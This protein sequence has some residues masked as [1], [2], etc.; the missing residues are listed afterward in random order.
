MDSTQIFVASGI[1]TIARA[2]WAYFVHSF[3]Q[4]ITRVETVQNEHDKNDD[5][6]FEDI[7]KDAATNRH[8]LRRD[9]TADLADIRLGIAA[10]IRRLD[11][12]IERLGKG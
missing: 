8:N 11:D 2:V 3:E 9:I 7:Q 12:K 10:E 5:R 6:R 1:F 4:R